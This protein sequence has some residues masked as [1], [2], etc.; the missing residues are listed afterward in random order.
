MWTDQILSKDEVQKVFL[1]LINEYGRKLPVNERE[2]ARTL[3]QELYDKGKTW[4]WIYWAVWQLG[5]RKVINNRGLFFFADYQ[6][7]VDDITKY[8]REYLGFMRL[9]YE[10]FM[11]DYVQY[12]AL[13]E[14][15]NIEESLYQRL[16]EL[17]DKYWNTEDEFTE[18]EMEELSLYHRDM[19]K[20]LLRTPR[21]EF[22]LEQ[23]SIARELRRVFGKIVDVEPHPYVD[24]S[25]YYTHPKGEELQKGIAIG[26]YKE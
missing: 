19:L 6:R 16:C 22:E 7:E 24:S 4:E 10:Q 12:L 5:E 9:T 13:Y 3:F 23:K 2:I 25:L 21:A 8:A 15:N 11:E 17:D 20:D 1:E 18:E 26:F 14:S